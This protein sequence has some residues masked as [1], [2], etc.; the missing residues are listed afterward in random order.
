MLSYTSN[1]YISSLG[2]KYTNAPILI[3]TGGV[4][5]G[6]LHHHTTGGEAVEKKDFSEK[7]KKY[8]D[9]HYD[10][11]EGKEGGEVNHDQGGYSKGEIAAKDAKSDAGYYNKADGEKNVYQDEKEYG[12]GKHYKK[13]G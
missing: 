7:E 8:K 1:L 10:K 12:G 5:F 4:G 6:G 9:E 3:G 11:K 13:E 2:P